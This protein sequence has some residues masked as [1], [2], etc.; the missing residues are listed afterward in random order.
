MKVSKIEFYFI[1][2][3]KCWQICKPE[4]KKEIA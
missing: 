4:N 1:S 2:Q 3:K